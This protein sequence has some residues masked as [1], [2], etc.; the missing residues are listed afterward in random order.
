MPTVRSILGVLPPLTVTL[1]TMPAAAAAAATDL[2]ISV[3][4]PV[5]SRVQEHKLSCD[6]DGGTLCLPITLSIQVGRRAQDKGPKC[7]SMLVALR[8]PV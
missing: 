6:P 7:S 3:Y 2:T 4:D 8:G 1:G 5:G